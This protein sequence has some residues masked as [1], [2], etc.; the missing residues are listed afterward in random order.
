MTNENVFDNNAN[1]DNDIKAIVGLMKITIH[2][3]LTIKT[4]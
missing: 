2:A 1:E 4:H 3:E